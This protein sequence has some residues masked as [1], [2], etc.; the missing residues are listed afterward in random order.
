LDTLIDPNAYLQQDKNY[1]LPLEP[2]V[3]RK[4]EDEGK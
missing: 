1:L 2:K 3:F 4:I